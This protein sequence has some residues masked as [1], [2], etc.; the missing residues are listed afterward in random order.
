MDWNGF[1]RALRGRRLP[2]ALV[3]LDALD[4]NVDRLARAVAAPDKSLRVASKS[5]RHVGLLR[6]ILERGGERFRGLMCFT[7]EEAAFLADEGFDDLLVAY[8]SVQR[9]GLR[10][11]AARVAEGATIRLMADD[12]TQLEAYGR[13]AAE[14]G[15]TL[16]ALLELDVAYQPSSWV[17]LGVLRSP[18]RSA[19]A[20]A[21]VARRAARIEGVRIVGLMGYEAHVAGLPDDNPFSRALNPVRRALKRLAVPQVAERRRAAVE[22]LR[23]AGVEPAVV[24]GGGT[25]SVETTSTEPWVTEVTA[26]SGFLCSHLFDY[27]RGTTLEPAAFFALEVCRHPQPDTVTCLGGGYVASGEPGWDRLPIPW[28]PPGLRYVDMEGAG[29]VQTPLR[30]PADGPRPRIGDPVIFR[31]AKAGELAER[32]DAYHLLRGGEVVA[33]EPTYRGLGR[34]FL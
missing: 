2:A 11:V 1:S 10:A 26:G 30:L 4:R 18:L 12:E 32:F 3:D 28:S 9:E 20:L 33:T 34:C 29:E 23:A 16:E 27:Y 5:V 14:A 15:T 31:H 19:E 17:H 24:N 8:P 22:T 13:A 25:G 21:S 6:R 7:L